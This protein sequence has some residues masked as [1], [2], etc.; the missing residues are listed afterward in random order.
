MAKINLPQFYEDPYYAKAQAP[1]FE[2]GERLLTGDIPEFYR[3]IAAPGGGRFEAMLAS[4]KKGVSKSVYEDIARRGGRG[5][6]ATSVI[7]KTMGD[8]GAKLRWEDVLRTT[9]GKQFLLGAGAD[10]MAGVRGAGLTAGAGRR[11]FDISRAGLEIGEEEFA[12]TLAFGKEKFGAEMAFREKQLA[13]QKEQ[14]EARKKAQKSQMWSNIL[15]SAVGAA[16]TVG[17]M[18]MYTSALKGLGSATGAV[19]LPGLGVIKW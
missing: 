12:E 18:G 5:G 8:I 10:I 7:G 4:I 6:L 1:L 15:S 9:Q 19:D 13:F 2:T 11:A 17:G 16:G 3:D 14:V